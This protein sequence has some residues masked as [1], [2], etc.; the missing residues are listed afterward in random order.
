M[1]ADFEKELARLSAQL[2]SDT[3]TTGANTNRATGID[4][5]AEIGQLKSQLAA[6][7]SSLDEIIRKLE[8]FQSRGELVNV[9]QQIIN[10]QKVLRQKTEQKWRLEAF[11]GL[12]DD[13]SMLEGSSEPEQAPTDNKETGNRPNGS[14]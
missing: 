5:D 1:I 6:I 7:L 10:K 14:R 3:Q 2:R 8:K 9:L 4:L 13:E 12:L 11:E